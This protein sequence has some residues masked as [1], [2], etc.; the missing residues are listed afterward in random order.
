[1][2]LFDGAF[3]VV[4]LA[5]WLSCIVDVITTDQ[6]R[7]RN[8]PKLTWLLIVVALPDIGSIIWL[9]AGHT[10]EPRAAEPTRL[11][12]RYP[13]YDRPGR[14]I[15]ANPDDDEAFL[16]QVRQRAEEQ[17]KRGAAQAPIPRPDENPDEFPR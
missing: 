5:L 6:S 16:R 2:L 17:R 9:V 1:M 7:I 15:P 14:H 3:G 8:L 12:R 4:M 10:W 11:Q 13:E